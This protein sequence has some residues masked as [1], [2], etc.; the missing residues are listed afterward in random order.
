MGGRGGRPRGAGE[1]DEG[2]VWGGRGGRPRGTHKGRR[3]VC[4]GVLLPTQ[5]ALFPP[6][7]AGR[8]IRDKEAALAAAATGA[9]ASAE[10]LR[11]ELAAERS[12]ALAAQA[13]KLGEQHKAELAALA[14]AADDRVAAAADAAARKLAA[15]DSEITPLRVQVR[16][17]A[18]GG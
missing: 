17:A 12:A 11:A 13:Q 16:V 8:L 10:A 2:R 3:L 7:Q 14:K 18:G 15:M 1:E 4:F 5:R 6:V 9:A